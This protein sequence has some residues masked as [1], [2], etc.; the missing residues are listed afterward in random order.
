MARIVFSGLVTSIR[1]S[2][3]GTTFQRNAYGY[4]VKNKANM[5]LPN[6]TEQNLR[7]LIFSRAVKAWGQL[8]VSNRNDWNTWAAANP[9]YA[10]NNPSSVLSGY[11]V[12]VKQYINLIIYSGLNTAPVASPFLFISELDIVSIQLQ[13]TGTQLLFNTTWFINDESWWVNVYLTRPFKASQNFVGTAPKFITTTI[14]LNDSIDI[15]TAYINVFG[16]IPAVGDIIQARYQ[17]FVGNNGQV[18]AAADQ[19][20][21]VVSS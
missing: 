11:A 10:H 16:S 7:K 15:T 12:F 5:V 13:N 2:V 4:T 8:T 18:P 6:S 3:G 17:L 1:G 20:I 9:Q 21:I 19:R 14:S